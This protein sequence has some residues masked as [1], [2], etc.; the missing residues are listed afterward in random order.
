MII[1]ILPRGSR[2][3]LPSGDVV[4]GVPHDT[5]SYRATAREA[6]VRTLRHHSA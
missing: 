6:S 1:E 2:V 3:T 4:L 5:D